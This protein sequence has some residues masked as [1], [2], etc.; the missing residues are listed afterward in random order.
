MLDHIV[1]G[2]VDKLKENI[3]LFDKMYPLLKMVEFV[4]HCL[5]LP[6]LLI[7][8]KFN[9]VVIVFGILK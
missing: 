8:Q 2:L 1:G 6:H 9:E 3:K 4:I 5:L 7:R